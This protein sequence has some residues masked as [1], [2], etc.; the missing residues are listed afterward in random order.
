MFKANSL[1]LGDIQWNGVKRE[2]KVIKKNV[3]YLNAKWLQ[4]VSI[5]ALEQVWSLMQEMGLLIKCWKT[6]FE[7]MKRRE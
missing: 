2:C 3:V 6:E 1:S 7:Q 5:I 4:V